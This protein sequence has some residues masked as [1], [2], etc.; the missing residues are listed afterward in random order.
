MTPIDEPSAVEPMPTASEMRAP[1]MIRL[2]TSRPKSPFPS[3]AARSG[4]ASACAEST[5]Q[6]IEAA[7]QIGKHRRQHEHHHD[8][9]PT[10]PSV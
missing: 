9:E 2:Q 6:R 1:W 10:V 3:S 8:A 4:G 5:A 7:D